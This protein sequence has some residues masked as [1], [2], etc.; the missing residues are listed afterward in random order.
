MR[1]WLIPALIGVSLFAP[2]GH[3][4]VV[5]VPVR[6]LISVTPAESLAVFTGLPGG[7]ATDSAAPVTIVIVPAPFGSAFGMRHLTTA[8][9]ARKIPTVVIDLLGM[10]ASPR[11]RGADYSLSRQATRIRAVLDTLGIGRTLIVA[12]G[13]SATAALHLAAED[14][15]RV[16]GVLSL[17]GG[18]VSQQGTRGMRLVLAMSWLLDNPLGRAIGRRQFESTMRAE[19][20]D[21][22][23]ITREVM[24]QYL[25]PFEGDLRGTL[26]A[27][28]AMQSAVEPVLI[29]DRLRAIQAPVYL[30]MGD[31]PS[32]A[33]PTDAQILMLRER[34][35]SFRLD[36]IVRSGIMLHEEQ[37]DA[38]V[39]AVLSMLRPPHT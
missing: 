9:A 31:K 32:G 15:D 16:I 25:Q 8:L 27:L 34:L 38:V 21:D 29:A 4:D 22:A 10:G 28:R 13:T 37:P 20:A 11:P 3:G 12:Q 6:R 23:W 18:L 19:S 2:A 7:G 39:S 5:S 26:G 17:A 14:R 30:L 1:N 36:T 35:P 33:A 24:K